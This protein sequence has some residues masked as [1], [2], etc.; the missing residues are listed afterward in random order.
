M[1]IKPKIII[2]DNREEWRIKN[3]I[4]RYMVKKAVKILIEGDPDFK[5]K[6][7]IIKTNHAPNNRP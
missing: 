6:L 7:G 1:Y 5:E 3:T 2:T 4:L